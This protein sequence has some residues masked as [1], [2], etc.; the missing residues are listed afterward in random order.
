MAGI[1]FEGVRRAAP[2]A[3]PV[4][5]VER[6]L[7]KGAEGIPLGPYRRLLD[8][9]LAHDGGVALLRCGEPMRTLQ[10]PL[11]FALLNTD[12]PRL[13]IEKEARLAA[14]FHSRHRVLIEA[15]SER[16]LTLRHVGPPGEPPEPGEDLATLGQHIPLF[17]EIGCQGLRAR[18]PESGDPGRW[19]YEAGEVRM[20]EPPARYALM[21]L[22]WERHVPAR[23]PMP[24]L[25][26]LLL[27]SVRDRE[28]EESTTVAAQV[29]RVIRRDLGRTWRVA[30]VAE[31][32]GSS[33]RSLQRALA[34]EGLRYS[35]L[36]DQVRNEEAARLLLQSELTLTEIGYLCGFSDS[37]HFSRSFKRRY[38]QTPTAYRVAGEAGG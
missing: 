13:L 5:A 2:D 3:L 11:L 15:E 10:H 20:P 38:G 17:E 36:V 32:L 4:D 18:L 33:P 28:L 34:N 23:K 16:S 31:V 27:A 25:D 22:E 6:L 21:H 19:V 24:G 37:A 35:E 29:E 1:V 14:F 26:E 8:V 12:R 30:E 9:A 7:E